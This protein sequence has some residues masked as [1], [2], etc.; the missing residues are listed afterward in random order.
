MI[1]L[2]SCSLFSFQMPWV[3]QQVHVSCATQ[4]RWQTGGYLRTVLL[5]WQLRLAYFFGAPPER[6]WRRYYGR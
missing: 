6:L 2:R 3:Q 4:R 5:M 1:E